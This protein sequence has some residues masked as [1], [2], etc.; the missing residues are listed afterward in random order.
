MRMSRAW[1]RTVVGATVAVVAAAAFMPSQKATAKAAKSGGFKVV[2]VNVGDTGGVFQNKIVEMT[3]ST[4]IDPATVNP[5]TI[6]VRAQNATR[7]G[8]TIQVPGSFQVTG[9]IVRFYPRLP[10]H[11]RDPADPNGGFY[12]FGTTRDDADAN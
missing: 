11:L 7:T 5:A 6:R 8:Y 1:S 2:D 3:F 4:A 12:P 9:N 10:T